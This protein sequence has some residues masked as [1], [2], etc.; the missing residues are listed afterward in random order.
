MSKKEFPKRSRDV[1][2]FYILASY[3]GLCLSATLFVLGY[4]DW[5]WVSIEV[6]GAIG[7]YLIVYYI[8][9]N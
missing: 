9:V 6:I 7:G 5:T 4:L 8:E 3:L 1:A 2:K